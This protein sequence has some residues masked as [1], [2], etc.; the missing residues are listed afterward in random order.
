VIEMRTPPEE[1]YDHLERLLMVALER[2]GWS[3]SVARGDC[4]DGMATFILGSDIEFT[5]FSPGVA[6]V[7][8]ED[9]IVKKT[10]TSLRSGAQDVFLGGLAEDWS[11]GLEELDN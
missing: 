2:L 5:Y 1:V 6:H 3:I 7:M 10:V 9:L 8:P 4:D 11:M